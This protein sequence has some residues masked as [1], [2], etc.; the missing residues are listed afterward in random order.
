MLTDSHTHLY[1]KEFNNDLDAVI[2]N[3]QEK[4]INRFLLPN[5]DLS[6]LPV[7]IK[8]CHKYREICFPM[9]GLHPCSVKKN[10]NEE[11]KILYTQIKNEPFI[12][13]GEIG[14]DLYWDKQF[15]TQQT[16]AFCRQIQIAQEYNLPIVIHCRNAFN[17]IYNIIKLKEYENVRGIFHCFT[18]D[19]KQAKQIIDLGYKLG[20]GG[21]VSFKN[22]NLDS[23]IKKISINDIV[24]ETDSPYLAPEPMRG[25]RNEPKYLSIIAHKIA[26]LKKVSIEEVAEVTTQNVNKMF[27]K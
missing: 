23:V 22:S 12:A 18:G 3:A 2:K 21:I 1:L 11:L 8:T 26:N 7:L 20:V 17:Q 5:I 14:I 9:I 10:Y 15:A 25:K 27:F 16:D 13:I 4:F 19:Y 24:L 6:T